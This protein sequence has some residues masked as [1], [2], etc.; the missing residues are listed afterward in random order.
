MLAAMKARGSQFGGG[1][2]LVAGVVAAGMA[3]T[4]LRSAVPTDRPAASATG[5]A[6]AREPTRGV[7][8]DTV[9]EMQIEAEKSGRAAWGHWGDNPERYVAWSNHSNRLIPVYTFGMSLDAVSGT[10]SAYRDAARL[11][12]LY[13]RLP[14]QT[15][16]ADAAYFDQT[17]VYRLQ[18]QAVE[19]G[20]KRIV[21]MVFDGMDWHTT[22][23]AAIAA[24]GRVAYDSGRGTGFAFQD[25]AGVATDF[26]PTGFSC[27]ST[28]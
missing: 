18:M 25:Y 4:L 17:D 22:R 9:R 26:G 16:N 15:L 8:G 21:L 10:N 2:W 20:K 3:V 1:S 23:T 13:G 24:T 12:S 14:D 6:P 11:E 5:I 28:S 19:A 7:A 27:P